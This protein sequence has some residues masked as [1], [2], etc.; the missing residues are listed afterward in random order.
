MEA[1][2]DGVVRPKDGKKCPFRKQVDSVVGP[3]N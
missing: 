3:L 1:L 2:A